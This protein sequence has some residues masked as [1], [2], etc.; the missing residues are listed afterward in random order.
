MKAVRCRYERPQSDTVHR[1]T[2]L[3]GQITMTIPMNS[4]YARSPAPATSTEG[5]AK[6]RVG[7][8]AK[9]AQSKASKSKPAKKK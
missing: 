1:P 8:E 6:A 3:Q 4:H 2:R 5:P 9:K 7:V